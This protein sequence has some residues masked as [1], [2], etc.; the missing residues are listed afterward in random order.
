M[1]GPEEELRRIEWRARQEQA[2]LES[3]SVQLHRASRTL[4]R[5]GWELMQAGMMI[6]VVWPGDH[7]EGAPVWV[8]RDLLMLESPTLRMGVNLAAVSSLAAAGRMN[9]P[10]QALEGLGSFVAWCR[11]LE[12]LHVDVALHGSSHVSGRLLAVAQDHLLVAGGVEVAVAIADVAM[13][14]VR[15]ELLGV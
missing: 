10:P 12:G 13:V 15:L 8:E 9:T 14:S 5:F 2:E 11:M 6:R 1:N 3:E 7:I 4:A